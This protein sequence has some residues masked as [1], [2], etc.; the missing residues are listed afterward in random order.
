LETIGR[1]YTD[2]TA[3]LIAVAC[4]A[5]ELQIWKEVD[6]I[7][8]A[9][10]RKVTQAQKIASITPEEAAELT[11]YGSEV[12]HPFTMEQ[13]INASIPI[14]IKNTF[15][16]NG[17]GTLI[18]PI[19]NVLNPDKTVS[20]ANSKSYGRPTAVTVK[21]NITV[22]NLAS[23]RKSN[24]HG[25]FA[26]AF[27][28]LDKF[29]IIVDLI[30]TSEVNISMAFGSAG[31]KL[32][33]ALALLQKC[34]TVSVLRNMAIISLVGREMKN[35]VGVSSKMFGAL[36]KLSINIEMISQG[37]SEINIS[38]VIDQKFATL[39]LNAIHESLIVQ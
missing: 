12:I 15:N 4:K 20:T 22:L 23:N 35:T 10:P 16:P 28:I 18:T 8:T 27:S 34:G 3:A 33:Q 19:K 7:F 14:R 6:G 24:S 17:D 32:D 21:E 29:G 5:S 38:C 13:V 26:K 30:S 39:A 9:D 11:Y 1:G 25:F 37:A 2:L 31:E 36:A